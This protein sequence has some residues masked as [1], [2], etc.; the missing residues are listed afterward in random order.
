MVGFVAA[1]GGGEVFIV[2]GEPVLEE[3]GTIG[4]LAGEILTVFALVEF[5]EIGVFFLQMV[6]DVGR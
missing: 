4:V 2:V 6:K 5:R 3:V 1:V